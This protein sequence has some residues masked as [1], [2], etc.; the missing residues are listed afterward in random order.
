MRA[1]YALFGL[2][3]SACGDTGSPTESV[4]A[5]PEGQGGVQTENSE[6]Q[7]VAT[8]DTAPVEPVEYAEG[9]QLLAVAPPGWK[10]AFASNAPGL[11]MAEYIP[12]DESVERWTQKIT[13]ESSAGVPL[14][15]PI[16]F[17]NAISKDQEGTC[18]GF[19][20]FSTFSGLENGYPT[21]VHL[22]VCHHS[23]IIE[24]SQ[25]TLL[26]AIQGNDRFYVITRALRGPPMEADSQVISADDIAAWS[27]YLRAIGLC[28]TERA[29]HPC[30]TTG[31]AAP[32]PLSTSQLLPGVP[33]A[34]G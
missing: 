6:Q 25:V 4:T 28:D 32:A 7:R 23:T 11:R 22:L 1:A 30:G 14:P 27:L 2:L 26:K 9:E 3:L 33:R 21:S 34:A 5:S 17:V 29:G 16:E 31:Q 10:E 8:R 12:E 20:S 13:F 19:E 15:D 18:E 24:Q